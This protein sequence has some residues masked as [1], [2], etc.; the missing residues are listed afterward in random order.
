MIPR[1]A[2]LPLPD[3]AE[4]RALA[5][6]QARRAA[7]R[8]CAVFRPGFDRALRSAPPPDSLRAVAET[9]EGAHPGQRAAADDAR[10]LRLLAAVLERHAV[11]WAD[12]DG[13]PPN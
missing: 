12:I 1:A 5:V 11:G 9:I 13:A 8:L 4:V 2:D 6:E 7:Q 10:D 3:D